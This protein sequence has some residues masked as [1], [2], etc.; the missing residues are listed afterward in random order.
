M[1]DVMAPLERA[2]ERL[3]RIFSSS[4]IPIEPEERAALFEHYRSAGASLD[5]WLEQAVAWSN[6]ELIKFLLERRVIPSIGLK[7]L[8][9]RTVRP[10]TSPRMASFASRRWPSNGLLLRSSRS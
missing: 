3:R 9:E 10:N 7:A 5:E 2:R 4:Y 8:R 1:T 6:T